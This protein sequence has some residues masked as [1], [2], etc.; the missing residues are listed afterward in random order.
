VKEVKALM[1]CPQLEAP[2]VLGLL[3][4]VLVEGLQ[5]APGLPAEVLVALGQ[6]AVPVVT[7]AVG[8]PVVT[9]VV[10]HPAVIQVVGHPA[11]ETVGPPAVVM[12]EA[13]VEVMAAVMVVDTVEVMVVVPVAVTAMAVET[14][15][16]DEL[17]FKKIWISINII[18][19]SSFLYFAGCVYCNVYI[20]SQLIKKL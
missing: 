19:D 17:V 16:S 20:F 3:L 5:V 10:G 2:L 6:V 9:Q 18:T 4:K 15:S 12:V 14:G 11:M 8:H 7:Q 1:A 13:M